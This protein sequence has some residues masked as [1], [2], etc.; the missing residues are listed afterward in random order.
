MPSVER[1]RGYIVMRPAT[2]I[3][4]LVL[5]V[6][7]VV[8]ALCL[9]EV[10]EAGA[11]AYGGSARSLRRS[12]PPDPANSPHVV[13][14]TLN[15]AH[16]LRKEKTGPLHTSEIVDAIDKTAAQLRLRH[17]GRVMYV[18]KDRESQ[19]N[20]EE[21]REL[22]RQAA[23]RNRVYVSI[24]EQYP[25]PPRGPGAKAPAEHSSRARDDFLMAVLASR[26]KCA[27]LT[28][29]RLRDFDRFRDNVSPFHVYEYSYWRKLPTRDFIRPQS[30]AYSR[31]R[32]PQRLQYSSYFQRS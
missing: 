5:L 1:Q 14:D 6:C 17:S 22:V 31:L 32:K 12:P 9:A 19:L 26:W 11:L 24:A 16:W 20:T 21:A 8:A 29:D 28:E 13:V 18:M 7:L 2:A 25:D 3:V 23:E 4:I 30:P 27:A 10:R 15:L